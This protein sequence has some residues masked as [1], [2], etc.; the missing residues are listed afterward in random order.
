[1]ECKYDK[2]SNE[3]T[4][5]QVYCSDRCRK[6]AS[7]TDN[8]DKVGQTTNSDTQIGQ[9][10]KIDGESRATDYTRLILKCCGIDPGRCLTIPMLDSLPDGVPRPTA[11]PTPETAGVHAAALMDSMNRYNGIKWLDSP[12]YA[13]VVYR[14]LV[15][16]VEQLEAEGQFVPG[17]KAVA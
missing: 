4:G 5:K 16:S 15:S 9:S 2:C 17:W 7:R 1:M 8:S 3:V 12:E 14:L 10:A 13:E 11:Q 6:A